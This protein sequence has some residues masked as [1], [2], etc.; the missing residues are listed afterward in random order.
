[1]LH[2][3]GM[4]LVEGFAA[5]AMHAPQQPAAPDMPCWRIQ[6]AALHA[7]KVHRQRHPHYERC[8]PD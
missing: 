4:Q 8:T 3:Q 7:L 2:V 5:Q 1:M 6:T